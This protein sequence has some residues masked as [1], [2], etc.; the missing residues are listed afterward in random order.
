M[1]LLTAASWP[2]PSFS[3]GTPEQRA[4]CTPDV[5]RLCSTFIPNP[6]DIAICLRERSSELSGACRQVIQMDLTQMP[7]ATDRNSTRKRTT[8]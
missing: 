6:D 7:G 4:A 8:R 2:V 1:C 5:F 3:Q